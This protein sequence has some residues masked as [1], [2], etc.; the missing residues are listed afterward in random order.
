MHQKNSRFA[1]YCKLLPPSAPS[2]S[3]KANKAAGPFC[4]TSNAPSHISSDLCDPP[5]Y[6][7]SASLPPPPSISNQPEEPPPYTAVPTLQNAPEKVSSD[8]PTEDVLHFLDRT[9]D[10]IQSLAL[11]YGVPQKALRQKNR[12]WADHLLAAR[13]AILIPGEYYKGGVSLSPRPLESEEEE[14]RKGK[15]RAWMVTCK[16]AEC[17]IS[18]PSKVGNRY[19]LMFSFR[20][21]LALLYLEQ[22]KYDLDIAVEA[23]LADEKWDRE[24]PMQANVKGKGSG[25]PSRRRR[26][27]LS[28]GLTGQIS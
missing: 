3:D 24:H 6:S 25:R 28:N 13:K 27:G 19:L 18:G 12:L 8:Q 23:Y 22:A 2:P 11:R 7:S 10:S 14:I 1:S 17:V 20:Y 15:L 9:Q 26:I 5:A 4:Q 21:D 16:V